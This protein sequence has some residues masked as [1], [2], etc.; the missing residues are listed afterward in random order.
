MTVLVRLLAL[1]HG[2]LG[3]AALT[4]LVKLAA[5]RLGRRRARPAASGAGGDDRRDGRPAEPGG[6]A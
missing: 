4:W 6:G 5:L 3:I 1:L 2:R